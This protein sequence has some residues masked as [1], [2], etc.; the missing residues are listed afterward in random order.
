MKINKCYS[1][2]N[3]PSVK[4]VVEELH[5]ISKYEKALNE[6]HTKMV[7]EIKFNKMTIS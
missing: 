3:H 4:E 2:E 7:E 1:L 5:K 6:N